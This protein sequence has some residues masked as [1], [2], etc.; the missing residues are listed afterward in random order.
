MLQ[1]VERKSRSAGRRV[2]AR[3]RRRIKLA[4]EPRSA[5]NDRAARPLN[6]VGTH[7]PVG[8]A[9]RANEAHPKGVGS[10]VNSGPRQGEDVMLAPGLGL[11]ALA[12]AAARSIRSASGKPGKERAGAIK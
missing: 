10:A 12:G 3:G 4:L 8:K 5:P 6:H 9:S 11:L 7:S 1:G 2:I